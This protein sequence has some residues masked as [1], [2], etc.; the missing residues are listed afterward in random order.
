[1][2]Q[3]L[4]LNSLIRTGKKLVEIIRTVKSPHDVLSQ[5]ITRIES[6]WYKT[7]VQ[8]KVIQTVSKKHLM[9][10]EH[11][12]VQ[13]DV[14]QRLASCLTLAVQKAESVLEEGSDKV[15]R[16]KFGLRKESIDK[17]IRELEEWQRYYD[18]TWYLVVLINNTLVDSELLQLAPPRSNAA[19]SLSGTTALRSIRQEGTEGFPQAQHEVHVSLDPSVF[20]TGQTTA[21]RFSDTKLFTQVSESETRTFLVDSLSCG[22]FPS[23]AMA[24]SD[25]EAL[26]RRLKVADREASSLPKCQGIVKM[27]NAAGDLESIHILFRFRG[28]PPRSLRQDLLETKSVSLSH[29]LGIA[30][31]LAKSISFVHVCDFVH[32]NI[33]PEA[34]ITTD[35]GVGASSQEAFLL[36]FVSFRNVNFHTLRQ[37]DNMIERNLYRHP[38]RQGGLIRDNYVM[39]HDI[40]SLGVCLLEIGLWMSFVSYSSEGMPNLSKALGLEDVYDLDSWSADMGKAI[41]ERLVALARECL[42]CRMGDKYTAV[43]LTCLTCLDVDSGFSA[44]LEMKD[45]DGI[46]VGVRFIE[47]VLLRLEEISM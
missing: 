47:R 19:T 40:Y 42:P 3:I 7:S 1:M 4:T 23:V 2:R 27:K 26:A 32:K 39:Q 9:D 45:K 31:C 36:G 46:L 22:H 18:P 37:G 38:S 8:L 44:D 30:R 43:V 17:T 14:L 33:R 35:T 28:G 12:R 29:I 6:L 34:V 24:R 5:Q 15:K 21:I 16:L 11:A 20:D 10:D 41:K 13:D 25:S